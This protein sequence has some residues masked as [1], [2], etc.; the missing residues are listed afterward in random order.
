M[1]VLSPEDVNSPLFRQELVAL[2]PE[3]FVVCDYGQILSA[4]TLSV[5]PLG[6]I[7]L[8]GSLLPKY[9]GA[10]PI[11]W[12]IWRGETE[13]GIT[14]IHMTPRVDAGPCLVQVSTGIG[15]DETADVLEARLAAMGV[16]PVH[17]AIRQLS[18][19]DRCSPLGTN[20]DKA[21][22]TPARRLR[23]SDGGIDW[24]RTAVEIH[25]QFRALQPWPGVF[26]HWHP[27]NQP[28]VRLIL[29]KI[30]VVPVAAGQPA[31]QVLVSDGGQLVVAAGEAAIAVHRLQPAG[32]RSMVTAEFL[33]GYRVRVGEKW[34]E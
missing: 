29:E 10:A 20:Q 23:K 24:A 34:G 4:E 30:S 6:G 8:H 5:A 16:E 11:N 14:V 7:N 21:L 33:R 3:L 19:W 31:G 27:A 26:T 9:R 32:R 18:D 17:A 15:A 28:P 1:L 13:T 22:A 12:A 25:R 2:Q